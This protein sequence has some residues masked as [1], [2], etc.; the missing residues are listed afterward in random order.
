[1]TMKR[2]AIITFHRADN[3]GGVLQAFALQKTIMDLGYEVHIID[4][5]PRK[6][7]KN[8]DLI[9]TCSLKRF[10][11]SLL[12]YKERKSKKNAFDNFRKK[13]LNIS[14]SVTY[15]ELSNFSK[16]YDKLITGS[17]QVWNYELTASDG[18]YFL[19][20][21]EDSKKKISYAASFGIAD[22]PKE[23]IEWYREKISSFAQISVREKTGVELV[24]KLSGRYAENDI[25]PVFLLKKE[26]WESIFNKRPIESK[27]IFLYMCN[28]DII[29]FAKQIADDKN[30]KIVKLVNAKAVLH[31]KLNVGNDYIDLS[32]EDFLSYI[33]HADYVLT[34]S[35]HAMAFSI[36]FN[37]KFMVKSLDKDG[38]RI[39][40]LLDITN[41]QGRLVSNSTALEDMYKDINWDCVNRVV[42]EERRKSLNNLKRFIE[43]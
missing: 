5:S 39:F 2:I 7:C 28:T 16:R 25:D 23:K 22:I 36:I 8:Y 37:K 38:S 26:T 21:V 34:G 14:Q 43:V 17:D 42:Y 31:T 35:F 30:I 12:T 3:Y 19:D 24:K 32:P 41:L 4:Y 33:Y 13:N 10:I 6:I 40:D 9:D 18:V 15:S 20:F 29:N 11:K 1:M 27:Y